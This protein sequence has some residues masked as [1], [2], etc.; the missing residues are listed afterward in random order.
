VK[1]REDRDTG[2]KKKAELKDDTPIKIQGLPV[3]FW[4]K[5]I[6]FFL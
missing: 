3:I 6:D 4:K 2:N 1:E 5:S